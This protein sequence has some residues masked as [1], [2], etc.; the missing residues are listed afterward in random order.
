MPNKFLS[1]GQ[2]ASGWNSQ[3]E[4]GV[5]P[6]LILLAAVGLISFLLVSNTFNFKDILF[7]T[8]F[9]KPSSHAQEA[10]NDLIPDQYIVVLQDNVNPSDEAGKA[11]SAYGIQLLHTYTHALT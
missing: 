3:D 1:K 4:A 8:L 10:Q 6:I 2:P 5:I 9:P 7:A 11:Q